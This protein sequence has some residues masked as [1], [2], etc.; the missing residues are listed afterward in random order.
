MQNDII[1][2]VFRLYSQIYYTSLKT[3]RG[4]QFPEK[5][6]IRK[7]KFTTANIDQILDEKPWAVS[8]ER[9]TKCQKTKKTHH[10]RT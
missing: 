1:N 6:T 5:V 3:L 10:T 9:E 2:H 4:A 8:S 7:S